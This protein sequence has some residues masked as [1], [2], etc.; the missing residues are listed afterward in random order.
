MYLTENWTFLLELAGDPPLASI[1]TV[2]IDLSSRG[3]RGDLK[4]YMDRHGILH[5][6]LGTDCEGHETREIT[7]VHEYAEDKPFNGKFPFFRRISLVDFV[8]RLCDAESFEGK[9]YAQIALQKKRLG[10]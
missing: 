2:I 8:R 7:D 1:G 10:I 4:P 9:S 5:C 3:E 6:T